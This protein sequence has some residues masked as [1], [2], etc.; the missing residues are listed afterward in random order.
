MP[1]R[2]IEPY[3]K[4][5]IVCLRVIEP[6]TGMYYRGKLVHKRCKGLLKIH[7]QRFKYG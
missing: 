2:P 6:G 1:I 7:W 3:R 4:T 5:C